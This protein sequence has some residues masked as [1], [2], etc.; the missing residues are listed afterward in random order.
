MLPIY[1]EKDH[2]TEG[3]RASLALRDLRGAK[4]LTLMMSSGLHGFRFGDLVVYSNQITYQ[5]H[6][7][8]SVLMI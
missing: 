4:K 3:N 1:E 7:P 8:A 6:K 2:L 5:T